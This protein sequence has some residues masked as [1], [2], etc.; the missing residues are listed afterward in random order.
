MRAIGIAKDMASAINK[1]RMR[2][3]L[4]F[5]TSFQWG[6]FIFFKR[7]YSQKL[8]ATNTTLLF[9]SINNKAK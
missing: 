5:K 8:I 1:S 7:K 3:A 6:I 9:G 4:F 2:V